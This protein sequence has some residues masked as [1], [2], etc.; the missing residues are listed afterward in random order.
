MVDNLPSPS[1]MTD[2]PPS[3]SP[4]ESPFSYPDG[5]IIL[6]SADGVDLRV[7]TT[8]LSVAS[9]FFRDM[10]SLPQPSNEVQKV[11]EMTEKADALVTILELIYP[12][13]EPPPY[14]NKLVLDVYIAVDK[15]QITKVQPIAR[16]RLCAWLGEL[17]NP[18]EAW[19]IAMRLD[20]SEAIVSEERRFITADT[21]ACL[22]KFPDNLKAIPIEEYAALI[23]TKEDTIQRA[24]QCILETFTCLRNSDIIQAVFFSPN[25]LCI[26]HRVFALLPFE[27]RRRTS[28]RTQ[29]DGHGNI[30]PLSLIC[31]K[32]RMY[33]IRLP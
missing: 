2:N 18:L 12:I 6:R 32:L 17:R 13:E 14:P 26:L 33:F 11:I 9:P 16:R 15:L 24:W 25:E 5:D 4:S 29:S 19:A 1:T 20:V 23:Q 8:L 30:T 7:H 10:F 22:E 31:Q 28:P 21:T 27:D 3:P